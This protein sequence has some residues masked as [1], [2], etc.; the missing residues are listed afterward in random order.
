MRMA[1]VLT[2]PICPQLLVTELVART[3]TDS[4]HARCDSAL[5]YSWNR[6]RQTSEPLVAPAQSFNL[7]FIC[8]PFTFLVSLLSNYFPYFPNNL[9]LLFLLSFNF[10]QTFHLVSVRGPA[11]WHCTVPPVCVSSIALLF[12]L[13]TCD[14]ADNCGTI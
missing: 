10:P 14:F 1:M 2:S 4:S 12:T 9:H 3:S 6:T 11:V 8:F 13:A 7:L 5:R